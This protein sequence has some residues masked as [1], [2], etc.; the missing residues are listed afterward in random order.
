MGAVV[1]S[2]YFWNLITLAVVAGFLWVLWRMSRQP[3][4]IEAF[5][6]LRHHRLAL[7]AVTMLA[8]YVGFGLLDSVAWRDNRNADP[9]SI[10]DRVFSRTAERTY[11]APF[12]HWTT[13]EPHPHPVRHWHLLGTDANGND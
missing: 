7:I 11:S 12:A 4:W 5:R 3:L 6:R 2:P 8:V 9:R 1:G 13:G 10:V